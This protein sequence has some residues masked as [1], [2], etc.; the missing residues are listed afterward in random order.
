MA[1][2]ELLQPGNVI[3]V[4]RRLWRVDRVDDQTFTATVLDGSDTIP[5]RFLRELEEENVSSGSLPPPDVTKPSDPA[6]Q[7]LLL[8]AMRL[9]LI[10]GSAPMLGLQRSRAIPEPYQLVPLLMAM[11]LPK[12]RLLI[13]DDVGVGKTIESGLI[14]GE[15]VARGL[16]NRALIV[17]PAS[18]REQWQEALRDFFHIETVIIAGHTR[19]ALERRLLPGQSPWEAFPF[20]VVS[21]DYAKM[22]VGEILAHKWDLAI[23]D[24]AHIAA[25]PHQAPG[26]SQQE[27]LRWEFVERLSKRVDHLLLLSATPHNGY[28]DSFASLIEILNPAAATPERIDR[29]LAVPHVV[30]RRRQ[31]IEAW[32]GAEGRRPFPTRDQREDIIDLSVAERNLLDRLRK[33][34]E[35]I[36]SRGS[37][38]L[39]FWVAAHFQR[40]ALSSPEALRK[41]LGNRRRA[42]SRRLV[43]DVA[44]PQAAEAEAVVMDSDTG[45]DLSD[46]Q[47]SRRVDVAAIGGIDEL[48]ELEELEQL[49]GK[50][51]PKLDSKLTY[52][53]TKLLPARLRAHRDSRRVLMFTRYQDTLDY[54]AKQLEREGQKEGFLKGITVFTIT[55]DMT[56]PDRRKVFRQFETTA[57]AICIATD[58]ISEGLDLQRACAEIV[59]YELPWNPNRLEQR[60]GRIDRYGQPERQVGIRALVLND[61]LDVTILELLVKKARQIRE[62]FGV[63][64]VYFASGR[65]LR[66]LMAQYGREKG[67]LVLPGFAEEGFQGVA[68][69]P[70][71]FNEGH[72]Q[73]VVDESFY[74]Q[75]R[76]RLRE[77]EASLRE[78]YDTV[79]K[80][81]EV[82]AFVLSAL[83]RYGIQSQPRDA[84]SFIL[85]A[86]ESVI[87][88]LRAELIYTF[89]PAMGRDDPAVEV[90]D[91]AHPLV[92]RLVDMVRDE[93]AGNERG[94]FSARANSEAKR[95]GALAHVLARFTAET[96]PPIVMEELITVPLPVHDE[97]ELDYGAELLKAAPAAL[98]QTSSEVIEVGHIVLGRPD[99]QSR[100]G[101]A[102][103][104]RR[105]LLGERHAGI[106]AL[107]WAWA[108]GISDLRLASQD[109]LAL[110]AVFPSRG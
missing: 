96:D 45:D 51:T 65:E 32:Y 109:I 42:V 55:G 18:L 7:D 49:A 26:R 63:C 107:G 13:A 99:L 92:M 6:E 64:P 48:R 82:S 12:V 90:L 56:Q 24:E 86:R 101:E 36:E 60:N 68:A 25:R 2:N 27:M 75:S 1:I 57:N 11:A 83:N 72:I 110:T 78:T 87:P 79:G 14:L 91:L 97:V 54:V 84:D 71:P 108:A 106:S 43:Q 93:A 59:H 38:V 74:G 105:A 30:Q 33:Y 98:H 103:D 19:S 94:R 77:V 31:D 58:C 69:V 50:I 61:P 95:V 37:S 104:Q 89:D 52:L 35:R 44:A 62:Q 28:T 29:E 88:E 66:A 34:T 81:E 22:H 17:V 39:N 76:V 46:E 4:R 70:D 3:R 80:P 41:S 100:L 20:V 8:R 10:H 16:V 40:R 102:V 53:R 5:T 23:V 85:P 9:S 67:Q 15:L 21:I 73:R 47:R